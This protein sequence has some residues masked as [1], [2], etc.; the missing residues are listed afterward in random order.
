MDVRFRGS[1]FPL[2]RKSVADLSLYE[3]TNYNTNTSE[4]EQGYQQL[5]TIIEPLVGSE[6]R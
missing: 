5:H 6:G 1:K 4:L 3:I 2:H